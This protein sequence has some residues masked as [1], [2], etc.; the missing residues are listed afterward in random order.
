[1]NTDVIK[2][3]LVQLGYEIDKPTLTKFNDALR[4]TAQVVT[5]FAGGMTK[6][7][8]EAGLAVTTALTG[9]AA[10]TVALMQS[11]ARADLGYQLLARRMYM[12]VDAARDMAIATKELGFSIEDIVWGPPELRQ[13]YQQLIQD[14]KQLT[15]GL[16][17]QA[18]FEGELRKIRDIEFEFTRLKV[19]AQ[20]FVIGLTKAL[21]TAL[22][23]DENG[24]LERLRGWN[25][26]LI[27]N[28]PKL[29][30]EFAQYLAPVLRDVYRIW[31]DIADITKVAAEQFI[32]FIGLLYNDDTL[33]SGA[34]NVENF[35]KAL[36]YMSGSV[37]KIFDAVRSVVDYG[38][39]HPWVLKLLGI[40]A[41]TAIG[42]AIGGP[43]GAGIGFGASVGGFAGGWLGEK[44]DDY[45]NSLKRPSATTNGQGASLAD[46][47]GA[48]A[49]AARQF[50]VDPAIALAV[51]QRESNFNPTAMGTKG[52]YGVMQ[53][54]PDTA[55]RLGVNQYDPQQNIQGGVQLLS[56]LY[57]QYGNW[58]QALEAYNGGKKGATTGFNRD[59]AQGVLGE[60]QKGFDVGGI[61]VTVQVNSSNASPQDIGDHVAQAVHKELKKVAQRNIVQG[62]GS[63]QYA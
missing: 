34:T 58:T 9:I 28:I 21:S 57:A 54:M 44:A 38:E 27:A 49:Q 42:G 59:Y 24:L 53:L 22:T 4:Q 41:A 45:L 10:G 29:S 31:Q 52:D 56:Q 55:R 23:G 30:Q 2:S 48:V 8:V 17:G 61:H 60:A 19:E 39:A 51:A 25:Q 62:R 33:K 3:Y 37:R 5:R 7:V 47:Q 16:G 35:G 13:R 26:W 46:I 20:Y 14:Q 15:A 1:M 6:D 32:K 50:G 40:G 12:T 63:F 36:D 18:G 11:T 43:L